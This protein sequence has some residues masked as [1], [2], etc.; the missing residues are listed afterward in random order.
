MHHAKSARVRDDLAGRRALKC[1]CDGSSALF[2]AVMLLE[3]GPATS[4]ENYEHH[5]LPTFDT[6]SHLGLCAR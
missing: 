3:T 2:T 6:G 5:A 4:S 1:L